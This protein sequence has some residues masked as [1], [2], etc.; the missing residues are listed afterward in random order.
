MIIV[1][2]LCEYVLG[3]WTFRVSLY[4]AVYGSGFKALGLEFSDPAFGIRV[5]GLGIYA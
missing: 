5:Q 3:T 1:Q 2:V 4:E